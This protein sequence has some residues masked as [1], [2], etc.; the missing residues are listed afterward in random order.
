MFLGDNGM[1][2]PFAKTNCYRASTQTAWIARWPSKI[3]PGT[4]DDQNLISGVDFLPTVL[5]AAGLPAVAGID[6]RSLLP[7]LAG[8]TQ[9][10]REF[11][12]TEINANSAGQAF[13]MHGSGSA[14]RL[15]LQRLGRRHNSLPQ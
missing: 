2:F 13:P 10:N 8:G 3:K 1:A 12:F 11:A 7:L 15:Y 4:C 14:I 5:E 6:G 9:P